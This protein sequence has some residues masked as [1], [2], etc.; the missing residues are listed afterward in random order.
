MRP[1]AFSS[2]RF[3]ANR[4][5]AGGTL[6]VSNGA[7]LSIGGTNG[8]PS[9]YNTV[10]LGA[11]STVIY[12]GSN[13]TVSNRSYGHLTL[14]GSGTDADGSTGQFFQL[15][16]HTHIQIALIMLRIMNQCTQTLVD[17][18][19]YYSCAHTQAHL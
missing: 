7:T 19:T 16:A 9:N 12:A 8:F 10:T 6:T 3:S 15:L 17:R 1:S 13:Q 18:M 11:T 14:N 2:V 5:S 4:S